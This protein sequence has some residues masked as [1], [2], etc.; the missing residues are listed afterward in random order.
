MTK[1]PANDWEWNDNSE[2]EFNQWFHELVGFSFRSEWFYDDC[3]IG[4][5]KTRQDMMYKWVHSAFVEGHQK[6][7]DEGMKLYGGTE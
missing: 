6:G 5:E 3:L 1:H 7:F 4:D 2:E